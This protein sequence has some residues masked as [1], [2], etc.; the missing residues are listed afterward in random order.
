MN[1]VC[2]CPVCER[3]AASVGTLFLHVVNTQDAKHKEWLESYCQSNN[4]NLMKLL[5]DRALDKKDANKPLTNLFKR[6]FC[7]E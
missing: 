6:D 7:I 3:N 5:A 2:K 4:I 1:M